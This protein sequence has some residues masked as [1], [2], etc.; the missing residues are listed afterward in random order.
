MKQRTGISIVIAAVLIITFGF[1]LCGCG[2]NPDP[3]TATITLKSNASTGYA[4]VATQTITNNA[5]ESDCF[6][7]SDEYVEPE[8]S[9]GLV[10]VAGQ[11]VFTLKAVNPG[12]VD[13][14]LKYSR[15]WEPSD[16]DDTVIYQFEIDKNLQIEYKGQYSAISEGSSMDEEFPDPVI[17]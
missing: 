16:D 14:T 5:G 13:V 1:G 15:S 4:W 3:Q 10:G 11:Q 9:E 6:E 17:E 8:N 7:I 12:E 2:E